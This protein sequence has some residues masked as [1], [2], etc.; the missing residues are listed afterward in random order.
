MPPFGPT[1]LLVPEASIGSIMLWQGSIETIPG[2]WSLCDGTNGTPDLRNEFLYGN[3]VG[4]PPI[5]T[6]GVSSH[7]HD[8]TSD[9]H[10]HTVLAGSAFAAGSGFSDTTNNKTLIGT[11][12]NKANLPP[13]YSL[14]YIMFTGGD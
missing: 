14:A 6:G 10:T 13:Y 4:T 3:S 12:D 5:D 7:D 8:F 1:A 11:T 2:S 9:G